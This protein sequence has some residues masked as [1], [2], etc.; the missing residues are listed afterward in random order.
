MWNQTDNVRGGSELYKEKLVYWND[1]NITGNVTIIGW[2]VGDGAIDAEL[3]GVDYNIY[4]GASLVENR[5]FNPI[6]L[7]NLRLW[8]LILI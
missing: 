1:S 2:Y 4:V 7:K 3:D 5:E 6:Y 8:Q